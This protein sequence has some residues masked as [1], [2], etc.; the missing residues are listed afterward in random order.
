[1]GDDKGKSTAM[2]T[3]WVRKAK[4][5]QPL[6]DPLK[7][8]ETFFEAI[9][10]FVDHGYLTSQNPQGASQVIH[11]DLS[12]MDQG[13]NSSHMDGNLRKFVESCAKLIGN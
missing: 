8:R 9:R 4:Q 11:S 1:M 6:F 2:G 12:K 5:K 7:E 10:E 13:N 3:S